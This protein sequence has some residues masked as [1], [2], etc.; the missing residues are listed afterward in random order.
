[1]PEIRIFESKYASL[2]SNMDACRSALSANN[3]AVTQGTSVEE[4]RVVGSTMLNHSSGE[5]IRDSL[6]IK[7]TREPFCL[8][9]SRV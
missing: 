3:I 8:A 5:F 4:N 6:A 2:T 1:M 7:L 9:G